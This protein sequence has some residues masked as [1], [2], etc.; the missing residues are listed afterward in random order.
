METEKH[1]RAH[2]Y[3]ALDT[4]AQWGADPSIDGG[5]NIAF[6]VS[7]QGAPSD[8]LLI[9]G[10]CTP[11]TASGARGTLHGQ[12]PA[13]TGEP[14]AYLDDFSGTTPTIDQI[15][16]TFAFDL[17]TGKVTLAGAFPGLPASLDFHVEFFKSFDDTGGK[18][19]LFCSSSS[20]D[21]AGYVLAVQLVGAA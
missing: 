11:F 15:A 8:A 14:V 12:P 21:H 2:T 1:E 20:S 7:R 17:N 6:S 19:V 3:R 10:D 5:E 13:F 18:N 4:L 16:C 9:T